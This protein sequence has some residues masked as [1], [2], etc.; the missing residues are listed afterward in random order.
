MRGLARLA[1]AQRRPFDEARARFWVGVVARAT[2]LHPHH[3]FEELL[4]EHPH[5]LDASLPEIA[6]LLR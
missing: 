5:L 3:D 4:D 6:P 1:E 2:E